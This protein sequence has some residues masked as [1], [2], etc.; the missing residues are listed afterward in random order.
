L[1]ATKSARICRACG[2]APVLEFGL[3]RAQGIDGGVTASRAAYIGG[4]TAT[5]NL[6]AGKLFEIPVRGTHAHSWVMAFEDERQ[7]FHAYADALPNNCVFL[8]DTYDTLQGVRNAIL[9]AERLRREGHEIV[10]IRLD[11]GDMGQ[12]SRDARRLLD[13]AGFGQ[14]KI[15]ASS[16]L[17]EYRIRKLRENGA[18]IDVWGVGTRLVTAY[19]QAALG[20]VY[21]LSALRNDRGDWEYKLKLSEDETKQSAPGI[22]QVRRFCDSQG[23]FVA[24]AIYDEP[25]GIPSR[26]ELIRAA[27]DKPLV[28]AEG[29]HREDLLVPVFRKGRLVYATPPTAASR[30]RAIE[31][32]RCLPP[33]VARLDQPEPYTVGLERHFHSLQSDLFAA[34]RARCG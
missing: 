20:G 7:A 17:D 30:Q 22:L 4:C 33:Q 29:G 10:G 31:Q 34:A 12:L 27:S 26:V 5:S 6:L 1:V 13:E 11:S 18:R 28:I 9:T 2:D 19:D 21:K 24:D 15:V 25:R 32:V 16:D 14:A 8:V 3:R 23:Q